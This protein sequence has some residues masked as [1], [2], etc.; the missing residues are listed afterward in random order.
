M[1]YV[2]SFQAWKVPDQARMKDRIWNAYIMLISTEPMVAPTDE[3]VLAQYKEQK[4]RLLG[5]YKEM[6][7]EKEAVIMDMYAAM[8]CEELALEQYELDVFYGYLL[9]TVPPAKLSALRRLKY[10]IRKAYR[11]ASNRGESIAERTRASRRIPV[12]IDRLDHLLGGHGF[13]RLQMLVRVAA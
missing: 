11:I 4:E 6:Y 5:K 2:Q 12:L 13:L 9:A 1:T 8:H 7:G 10:A 3:Q